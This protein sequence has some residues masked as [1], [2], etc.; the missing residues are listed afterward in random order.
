[1]RKGNLLEGHE[2]SLG[3]AQGAA[4]G[5]RE[6]ETRNGSPSRLP[7]H[8]SA[9]LLS[10]LSAGFYNEVYAHPLNTIDLPFPK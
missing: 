5:L 7:L 9:L 4:A 8:L 6:V 1:M 3:G 2:C 10:P